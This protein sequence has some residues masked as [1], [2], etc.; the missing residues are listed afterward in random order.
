MNMNVMLHVHIHGMLCF[1]LGIH[2]LEKIVIGM[3]LGRWV[4][5]IKFWQFANGMVNQILD[6]YALD[7]DQTDML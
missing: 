7:H 4:L 2:E 3:I 5:C 1:L 6:F